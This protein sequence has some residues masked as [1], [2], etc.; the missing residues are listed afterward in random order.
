MRDE[1][2]KAYEIFEEELIKNYGEY[3]KYLDELEIYR[4]KVL[5]RD[6]DKVNEIVAEIQKSFATIY[7]CLNLII[8]R[9]EFAVVTARSYEKFIADL[10]KAGAVEKPIETEVQA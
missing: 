3:K 10:K 8:Q 4:G 9:Y 5:D 6:V 1:M 2:R 7:P